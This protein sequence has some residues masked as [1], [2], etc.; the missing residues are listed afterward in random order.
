MRDIKVLFLMN[1]VAISYCSAECELNRTRRRGEAEI[2]RSGCHEGKDELEW[3][4]EARCYVC[5]C[6]CVNELHEGMSG[7]EE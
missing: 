1:E 4:R 2:L 3:G 7:R 6:V 5:V